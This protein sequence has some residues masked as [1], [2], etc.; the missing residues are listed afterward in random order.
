MRL[1]LSFLYISREQP[2]WLWPLLPF[3]SGPQLRVALDYRGNC[4]AIASGFLKWL[5]ATY[6]IATAGFLLKARHI[7]CHWSGHSQNTYLDSRTD[8]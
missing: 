5:K 3:C 8:Y 4:P 2:L 1:I 6:L 7:I